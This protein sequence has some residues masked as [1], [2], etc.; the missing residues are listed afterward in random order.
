VLLGVVAIAI[1]FIIVH[2]IQSRREVEREIREGTATG[3]VQTL[4]LSGTS[5]HG[6][7]R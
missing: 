6:L 5:E 1:I 4:D 3:Q 7:E 2:A